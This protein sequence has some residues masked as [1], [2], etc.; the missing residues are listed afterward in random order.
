M[1]I[2]SN[3]NNNNNNNNKVVKG[4]QKKIKDKERGKG[5]KRKE[6]KIC[7]QNAFFLNMQEEEEKIEDK[8]RKKPAFLKPS[9]RKEW[10]QEISTLF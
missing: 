2:Y 8:N 1:Y 6:R 3:N 4:K 7:V 10:Q 9:D 5:R